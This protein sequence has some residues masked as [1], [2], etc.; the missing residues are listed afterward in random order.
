M[1]HLIWLI[2]LVAFVIFLGVLVAPAQSVPWVT[3]AYDNARSGWNYNESKLTQDSV[4][5]KGVTLRNII[6]LCCDARGMEA[7]PLIVPNVNGHDMMILATM[8]DAVMAVDAHTGIK[9]WNTPGQTFSAVQSDGILQ[10]GVP[11]ASSNRIDMWGINQHYGCLSTGVVNVAT[12]RLYQSCW[13][14]QDGSTNPNSGRYEMFVID[15]N[16]GTLVVPP[17]DLQGKDY[18]MWKQRAS[19]VMAMYNDGR[20]PV[21]FVAHGSV[22][23]TSEG[24]TGGI[25]AFDCSLNEVTAQLPMTAG[26]WMAGQGLVADSQGY[27]YALTG[28]G[29]FDPHS[30]FYGEAFIKLRYTYGTPNGGQYGA[31]LEVIDQWSPW[32][33]YQRNGKVAP[34]SAPKLSSVS[35]PSEAVTPVGGNMAPSVVKG[36]LQADVNAQNQIVTRVYP[37]ATG[38]WADE[39]W[40]SAGPGCIFEINTCVAAGKDGIGYP[41]NS[42]HLGQTTAATVGTVGN[43]S[44]LR[45]KCAWLTMSPGNIPCDPVDATKLNF[46]PN[47]LTAHLH[48]TPV[49]IYD[50]LLKSWVIFV[51]GENAALHKWKVGNDGKLTYIAEGHEYAS[52]DVRNK[53]PGGMPGG[54][55]TASSNA[56]DD[57]SYILACVIPYGDANKTITN[58]RLLI[59]D[60]IHLAPDGHIQVLWDSQ[61]W[62]IAFKMNKFMAPVIDGG[63][64]I[65][66]D[67]GGRVLV[68]RE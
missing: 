43:Y 68:F 23:E 28:N 48:M 67:Y 3:R 49:H 41:I 9:L 39:D 14:T 32:N 46:F 22:Y 44:K 4:K 65:V 24:Y 13:V 8:S 7:Q 61:D 35:Q 58:G 31:E 17:V 40:G 55:C 62:G 33:D 10:L 52:A 38:A 54:F 2:L 63:D 34:T 50:P 51:W 11:V 42:Y 66:P 64:I 30:G 15:I 29:D 12:K 37:M 56:Q 47:G 19:L 18:S 57:K 20:A 25:T 53:M 36:K 45:S 6:P 59:Y 26:I 16:T 27:L 21:V 1:R 60:P 5:Y